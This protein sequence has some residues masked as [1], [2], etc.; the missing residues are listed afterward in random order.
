MLM[1]LQR[2]AAIRSPHLGI[3]SVITA[4]TAVGYVRLL[5][6][7]GSLSDID[8]RVALVMALLAGFAV[9]SGVGTFAP[10]VGLRA[11]IAGACTAGL[12]SLGL[13]GLW[14]IGLVLLLASGFAFVAWRRALRDSPDRRVRLLSAVA[15]IVMLGIAAVGIAATG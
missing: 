14:S 5:G 13:I 2:P 1:R 7:Q 4:T 11:V 15:A 9:A 3:A 12:F 10:S 6:E 8:A